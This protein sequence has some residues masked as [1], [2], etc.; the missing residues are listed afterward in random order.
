MTKREIIEKTM[1][2]ILLMSPQVETPC[3]DEHDYDESVI[4]TLKESLR[5]ALPETN[6][7]TCDDFADLKVT[8]CPICHVDYPHFDMCLVDIGDGGQAW[9]C[10]AMRGA[11]FPERYVQSPEDELIQRIFGSADQDS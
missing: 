3:D 7:K 1:R 8:C 5:G 9:I 4:S 11:L 10:C 6:I 2:Q